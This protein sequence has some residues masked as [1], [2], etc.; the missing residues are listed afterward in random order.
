[1][2]DMIAR[3][4]ILQDTL[5]TIFINKSGMIDVSRVCARITLPICCPHN[6]AGELYQRIRR[7]RS[8]SVDWDPTFRQYN[9]TS[10]TLHPMKTN[11]RSVRIRQYRQILPTSFTI[12]RET[13]LIRCSGR[14]YSSL[15]FDKIHSDQWEM[16]SASV[17]PL[18]SFLDLLRTMY[19]M[20]NI[21]KAS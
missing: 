4:V 16:S 9:N 5:S 17:P 8:V 14:S 19:K 11:N 13:G 21:R 3:S 7:T 18:N 2:L 15:E 20:A 1:M 12:S 10:D 6:L